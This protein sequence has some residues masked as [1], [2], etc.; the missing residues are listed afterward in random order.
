[1]ARRHKETADDRAGRV[2]RTTASAP[3]RPALDEIKPQEVISSDEA[4]D[5]SVQ[6]ADN[7]LLVREEVKNTSDSSGLRADDE[8]RGEVIKEQLKRG[9]TD[10]RP[11]D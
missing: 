6:N 5:P 7:P 10:V 1:M 4:A 11:A 3:R 8:A 9:A 2:D